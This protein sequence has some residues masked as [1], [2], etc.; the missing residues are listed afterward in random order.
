MK[1][2]KFGL[3][4]KEIDYSFS[5]GYFSE[6]FK[7]E[8]LNA[9][10]EN[11]DFQNIELVTTLLNPSAQISGINITIP[12]KESIIPYLDELQ[13][14][15]VNIGAVNTVKFEDGKSIGHNTDFY[16]FTKALKPHLK[17][18]HKKALILGTGGASKAIAYSLKKLGITYVFVSRN[19]DFNEMSYHNLDEDI[20][21]DYTLIINCTPLGTHPNIQQK[22]QIPYEGIS[23]KHI[24]FDLIY[25]PSETAFLKQGKSKGATI[26]NGLKMLEFQA[27]KSW[28]IWNS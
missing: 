17:A 23:E 5:R 13:E 2:R 8:D 20:V 21:R 6:K 26:V 4:G 14:D 16:G 27:E 15:A 28:E 7:A 18:H 10:Y 24:M 22:P 9:T 3:L 12:Y 11:F 25:N 1:T 19:P